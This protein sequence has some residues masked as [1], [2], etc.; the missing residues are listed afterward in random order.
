MTY[1][2]TIKR[3]DGMYGA[4]MRPPHTGSLRRRLPGAVIMMRSQAGG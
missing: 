2:M 1:I 4:P 3:Q